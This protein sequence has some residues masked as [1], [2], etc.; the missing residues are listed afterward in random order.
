MK[1]IKD[2]ARE[3]HD[4]YELIAPSFGYITRPDTRIFDPESPNGKLMVAVVQNV[5]IPM[6]TEQFNAGVTAA[7]EVADYYAND[8]SGID[9]HEISMKRQEE[10]RTIAKSIRQLKKEGVGQI[11]Y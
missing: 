6:L 3:F 4:V 8:P 7:A 9:T 11:K 1:D 2:I 10:A 5:V